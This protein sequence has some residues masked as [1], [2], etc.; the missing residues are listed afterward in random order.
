MI[1][2]AS[3]AKFVIALIKHIYPKT[4]NLSIYTK[5]YILVYV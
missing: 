4:R 1:A 5:L 3:I 2:L